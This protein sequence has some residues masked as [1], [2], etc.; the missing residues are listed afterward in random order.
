MD[1]YLRVRL[2]CHVDGLSQREAASRFGIARETVRKMLRHSEP[3]GYRRRQPPKRPK[4]APFT[5]IIDRILEEDRTVHRK[6]HH[7]AKRI[8]ERLRDEH[9]FTGKETIVKDYVRERRLRRREMFVPLSHP[10]GH[11]QADFGEADAIIAGV[12]YRAHFFVMTLPHSDAC[13]VAAYPAA[14]TEAWLDGHNRAFV[15]FGGVPQSILYDNDKCLVSRILSDGTRQ[16][17]RAFSGLQSHYLFEDRYGRPGKGNDKGNVEGVVGYARRNFMTP[18]PR[19]ASWDAFNG[20]LEEQCRNRQGNVLRG[21]RESIGER[22]VRDREALKRPL[23]APFDACDKQGT[24][25]NSLS[26]V[27]YRTNDYSVPVAYG[28]QEVW[29]RGYVHEVVIGCG[30]GIIARHPRSYDREDMVFDPIHYLPLL[31]HKIGALDQAAPLAGWELPDAFPTL[32]R[33]LEA[34]MGKA[35]KREYVQVLRLLE[36]F[37]LE[38]LHG[39][40]KD[41]LRLGA[42]GYDAVKHPCAVPYRATPAQTRPGYLSLPASGQRGDHGRRQLYELVGWRR[43]MTDTPQVLLA[44]HLKTLKLP[45]FLREYD[46]LARQ[47]ATE[48]ADH[49]RYLVRLTE[50]ELIDRERRMVERR[51]RQA[52]FPAVKSLDS[53]DFKAIASLNKM[54]VL[55]LARC[56]YAERRENIIALGNSGTGKTHIALGLGLA[57]CQKGLSVGFLTAAALVHELM[58]ARDEKRLLRLQKQLAKYHL[59]I[60]DELGFVPLSKTGAELLFEVFSQRYERGSIL[61]TSNLPFDEWTEIF[62]SERLT[63]ALLDRLTHHVHIL[64]MNGES[65]R[66]NQSQKRRKSPKIPA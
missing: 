38:V 40:V 24:R 60:I 2:A 34:R 20:H 15:F 31:E 23:P 51:I 33:L 55:E 29:I 3:P 47:C 6:Q 32:R 5:D 11:A 9:G 50:L 54:L 39:A 61:V 62:G 46:K 21:H 56:E 4:L 14:T 25:V 22:F 36:T 13:F 52:R 19:F 26:L 8:F 64:E 27:R 30:A 41:A 48:G 37:D 53:F 28:H 59:L 17:T 43:V 42:I 12:K 7:T 45:T 1:L 66:L 18:R 58:E 44:H 35:G 10:P 16:R 49:V 63:G 57:A 65:Y